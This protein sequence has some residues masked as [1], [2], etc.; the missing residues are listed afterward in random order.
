MAK[1]NIPEGAEV[2]AP[3]VQE[4]KPAAK[5]ASTAKRSSAGASDTKARVVRSSTPKTG[6]TGADAAKTGGTAP[7]ATKTTGTR[8]G[9]SKTGTSKTG[10]SK[11]GASKT[12]ATKASSTRSSAAKAAKTA[13][14]ENADAEVETPKSEGSAAPRKRTT[15][16]S[17]KKVTLP[18][19]EV[20]KDTSEA[21]PLPVAVAAP[22]EEQKKQDEPHGA[23]DEFEPIDENGFYRG[24]VVPTG[25]KAVT[26]GKEP[27]GFPEEMKRSF[28]ARLGFLAAFAVVLVAAVFIF[29]QRP[30]SYVERT[31]EINFFYRT[32]S[33]VTVICTE[34][35][36]LAEVEGVLLYSQQN[37]K[38][39][40]CAALIGD[41]LYLISKGNASHVADGVV[42]LVLAADG[43]AVA[44]R[45]A[46]TNLY[47][48]GTGKKD[49]P[50]L[51]TTK[52]ADPRYA[53][54]ADGKELLYTWQ[55]DEGK[56]RIDIESYTG[57]EPYID[58]V[59]GLYPLAI[60]AKC[61]YIY[62][63][64]AEGALYV[65]NGKTAEKTRCAAKVDAG[66]IV[67]NRDFTEMIFAEG[68]GVR[69]FKNG[70]RKLLQ[71]I[72]EAE[73]LVLI[74]NRR[75]AS[76]SLTAAVQYMQSSFYRA[77]YLRAEGTG[78]RLSY[79]D[80]R[81]VLQ[82][83][84]FVDG[85]E[86]VTVTDKGAY[87]ISTDINGEDTHRVLYYASE[88]KSEKQRVCWG[89]DTYCTNVDGGRVMYTDHQGA[90]YVYRQDTGPVR[91]C[92][93]VLSGSLG[94]TVDD[95]FCFYSAEGVL[96]VSDNGRE[97]RELSVGVQQYFADA[98][99]VYYVTVTDGVSTLHTNYRGARRSNAVATG[100]VPLPR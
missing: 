42:D 37:G 33:N 24:A 83:I 71:G 96:C 75:V 43:G 51:I 27:L 85:I 59:T 77:Y 84:S 39:S 31:T 1:K 81:G 3:E 76:R 68:G 13:E 23:Q 97:L 82:P 34:G 50:S 18:E 52:C 94:V 35:K 70:E 41:K 10:T 8:S 92:D 26:E 45:T 62:Y 53:L 46:P 64:D 7:R 69:F 89:V 44:Y 28:F 79:L 25:G 67:F 5:R 93:N 21:A 88:G 55:N 78:K 32:E 30:S 99:T 100:I 29:L 58:T 65:F 56:L 90:L 80:R 91:L 60:S 87:F 40:V 16:T 72:T 47:Y 11:T 20:S 15:R 14:T 54:S 73:G 57:S 66:S 36:V 9:T 22:G 4:E 74:P 38:G 98:H 49:I 63:T 61:R 6:E 95:L 12:G 2:T 17:T 86:T 19:G 48:R